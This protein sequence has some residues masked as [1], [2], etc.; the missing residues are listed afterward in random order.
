MQEMCWKNRSE[1]CA[2][3]V[4]W[5][6]SSL[7]SPCFPGHLACERP[8]A[9]GPGTGTVRWQKPPRFNHIVRDTPKCPRIFGKFTTAVVSVTNDCINIDCIEVDQLWRRLC[10][11]PC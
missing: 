3:S 10:Q 11:A 9:S 5:S 1:C 7:A 2:C 8:M 6:A 4:T